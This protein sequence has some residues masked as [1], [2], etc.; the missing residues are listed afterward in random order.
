MELSLQPRRTQGSR[1]Q[2]LVSFQRLQVSA[3][4]RI[5]RKCAWVASCILAGWSPKCF[6]HIM[7]LPLLLPPLPVPT[8]SCQRWPARAQRDAC[9]LLL[10]RREQSVMLCSWLLAMP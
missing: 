7:V 1:R 2:V 9:A 8:H 3:C 6:K 5:R 10:S 4:K